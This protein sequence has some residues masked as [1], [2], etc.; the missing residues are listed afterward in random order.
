MTGRGRVLVK[1]HTAPQSTRPAASGRRETGGGQPDRDRDQH[2]YRR[3]PS[4]TPTRP[5][6]ERTRGREGRGGQQE[7]TRSRLE[8]KAEGHCR[9]L[10]GR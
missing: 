1:P 2:R 6:R 7:A 5:G 3:D 10:S 8:T 4:T 9:S